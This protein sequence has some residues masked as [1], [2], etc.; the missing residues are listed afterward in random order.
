MDKRIPPSLKE[1]PPNQPQVIADLS[2]EQLLKLAATTP[3][4]VVDERIKQS[5]KAKKGM[6]K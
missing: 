3:K 6:R 1:T 4:H 2:F 5:K